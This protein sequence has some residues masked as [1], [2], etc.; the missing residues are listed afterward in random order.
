METLTPRQ[1][2]NNL[3]EEISKELMPVVIFIETIAI[4]LALM[5]FRS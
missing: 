3:L 1:A 5:A 4:I 2:M